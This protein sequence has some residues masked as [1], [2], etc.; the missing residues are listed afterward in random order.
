MERLLPTLIPERKDP[1]R[2]IFGK[3]MYSGKTVPG[4]QVVYNA[5]SDDL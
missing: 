5:L 2:E 4:D 1:A 3:A